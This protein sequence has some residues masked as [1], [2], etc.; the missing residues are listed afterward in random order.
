MVAVDFDSRDKQFRNHVRIHDVTTEEMLRVAKMIGE[1]I[2]QYNHSNGDG[3]E[4]KPFWSMDFMVEN[5]EIELFTDENDAEGYQAH[6][7]TLETTVKT[8]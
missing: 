7:A 3:K 4:G 1:R 8:N 2:V 6:N 5:I